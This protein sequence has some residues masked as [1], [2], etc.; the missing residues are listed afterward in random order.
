MMQLSDKHIQQLLALTQQ[1]ADAIM[2]F[3][4]TD[5]TIKIKCDDSPVTQADLAASR[6]LERGLPAIADYPVLSEENTPQMPQWLDWQTYW[7][8][9]PIDGTKH[10]INASGEFCICI[11]LIHNHQSIFGLIHAPVTQT[12]WFA[13]RHDDAVTKVIADKPIQLTAIPPKTITATLSSAHLTKHMEQLL[14]CLPDYRWHCRGS[15]LKYIDI[16]EGTATLYPKMWDTCEWD[17]AAG[18]CLLE[19]MGGQVIDFMTQK[20]LSYGYKESLL[21]PHFLAYNHLS[22]AFIEQLIRN[23]Q[24]LHATTHS[25]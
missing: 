7:L 21:N 12:T 22:P 5:L 6:L 1:A 2:A 8:I 4:E 17:S 23:Y 19:C 24:R 9:D 15:A 18:Q 11:A 3:Y 13:H 14:D 10:F 25:L 16:I 20:P